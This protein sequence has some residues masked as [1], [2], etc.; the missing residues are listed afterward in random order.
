MS[1]NHGCLA[2]GMGGHL[3]GHMWPVHTANIRTRLFSHP[4]WRARCLAQGNLEAFVGGPIRGA[5]MRMGAI[6]QKPGKDIF[7]LL[8]HHGSFLQAC[9]WLRTAEDPFG[10]TIRVEAE[11]SIGPRMSIPAPDILVSMLPG[12]PHHAAKM[13][14]EATRACPWPGRPLYLLDCP[15][16]PKLVRFW[17]QQ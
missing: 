11:A 1:P 16:Q 9:Y 2:V 4:R 17:R 12:N 8:V 5:F 13:P 10:Y 15:T 7:L 14:K 3:P 6:G